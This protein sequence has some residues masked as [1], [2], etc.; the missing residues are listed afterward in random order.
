MFEST[1]I[2]GNRCF[3][4]N[5][6]AN[7]KECDDMSTITLPY[8][9]FEIIYDNLLPKALEINAKRRAEEKISAG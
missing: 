5:I 1:T 4:R 6:L 2:K 9:G 7:G 8:E 3:I